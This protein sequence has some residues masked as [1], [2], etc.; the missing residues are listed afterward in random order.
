MKIYKAF[1]IDT[2]HWINWF[3]SSW[4]WIPNPSTP[5]CSHEEIIL[6]VMDGYLSFSSTNRDGSHG[7]RW[8]DPKKTY[9]N[10]ERWIFLE[11]EVSEVK[12]IYMC[13]RA[14]DIT[15]KDY[16]WLG[17]AGFGTI[18]GQIL[19]NEDKWYCSEACQ[20]VETGKWVKRVSPRREYRDSLYKK[21][22]SIC[23]A[24]SLPFLNN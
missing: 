20:K 8:E 21:G 3:I 2:S 9:R 15:D 6:P 1:Y 17:I 22:W 5:P 18:T 14:N 12:I 13:K 24:S 19:N 10:P 7:T 11:K 4:T 23:G 16:D